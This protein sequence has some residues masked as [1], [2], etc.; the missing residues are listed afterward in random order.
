MLEYVVRDVRRESEAGIYEILSI[1]PLF[2]DGLRLQDEKVVEVE[3]DKPVV[4]D[5]MVSSLQ[6]RF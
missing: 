3:F 2:A 5:D 4:L 6:D 1:R